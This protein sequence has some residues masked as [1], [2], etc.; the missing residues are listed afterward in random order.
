[1]RARIASARGA[2][3]VDTSCSS[4]ASAREPTRAL[5][6]ASLLDEVARWMGADPGPEIRDETRQRLLSHAK[7]RFGKIPEQLL[8]DHLLRQM[9]AADW[10]TQKAAL[11]ALARRYAFAER[12]GLVVAQPLRLSQPFRAYHTRS[13][14][15]KRRAPRPYELRCCRSCHC[16]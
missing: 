12:D 13:Q 1:M 2:E 15:D 5:D 4:G 10:I 3:S 6:D 14:Q 8:V 16:V 11:D 9:E 7:R